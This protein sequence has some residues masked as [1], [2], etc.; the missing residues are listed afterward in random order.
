MVLCTAVL[1]CFCAGTG[2]DPSSHAAGALSRPHTC[3]TQSLTGLLVVSCA[4]V[5]LQVL[6]FLRTLLVPGKQPVDTLKD[7]ARMQVRTS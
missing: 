4:A 1:L 2:A 3:W 5:C 6:I 7:K